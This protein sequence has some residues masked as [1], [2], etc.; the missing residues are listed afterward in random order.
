M[1]G[2]F[3]NK[4][5]SVSLMGTVA[6]VVVIIIKK[7]LMSRLS[8]K[9]HLFVWVPVILRLVSQ[10]DLKSRISVY[11]HIPEDAY[12]RVY[13]TFEKINTST[14]ISDKSINPV[15]FIWLIGVILCIVIPMISYI[16]F[17]TSIRGEN[18]YNDKSDLIATDAGFLCKLKRVPTIKI[19]QKSVSPMVIG[20]I[21]PVIL[22]PQW[23][24]NE[25]SNEQM[26]IIFIHEYV[27]L[28]RGDRFVNLALIFLCAIYWF[29]P[30]IWIM[31]S[32][33]KKDMENVCDEQVLKI[34]DYQTPEV[35]GKTLLDLAEWS[36][37]S[38][39]SMFISPMASHKNT[40]RRRVK[41]LL[42][43]GKKRIG[44]SILPLVLIMSVMFLTGAMAE[45]TQKA[46]DFITEK[47]VSHSFS[48]DD[49]IIIGNISSDSD[50][51][52]NII[53]EYS[54]NNFENDVVPTNMQAHTVDESDNKVNNGIHAQ[55][56]E[57]NENKDD[58]LSVPY[59]EPVT[60]VSEDSKKTESD[61]KENIPNSAVYTYYSHSAVG[62]FSNDRKKSGFASD[63]GELKIDTVG[64]ISS[65]E[66]SLHGYF[67]VYK[68]GELI[69][70]NVRAYVNSS[71]SSITFSDA[72][73][74]LDYSFKVR[75]KTIN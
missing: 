26:K 57:N 38:K 13:M 59:T 49:E 58:A 19:S 16:C 66:S 34:M 43:F 8:P 20:L 2:E 61:T 23:V 53:S 48:T 67:N 47:L 41:I 54:Q 3:I 4:L 37:E 62:K 33:I 6:I 64:L 15:F 65:D 52:D 35:Y 40:L 28:K 10:V 46:A 7:L 42:G 29:N 1:T 14:V 36:I 45:D 56:Y 17:L 51:T 21:K 68:N 9:A 44:A 25:L 30:F 63:D 50:G 12:E 24:I 74:D 5:V 27:H 69:G 60:N 39:S 71:P 55:T 72:D 22:I 31:A 32:L 11:N 75:E 18:S 73:G 70:E